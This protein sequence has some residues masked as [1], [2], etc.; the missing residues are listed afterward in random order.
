[1]RAA[2]NLTCTNQTAFNNAR[3][4]IT[5]KLGA[6]ELA[7]L[8]M[9]EWQVMLEAEDEVEEHGDW[10]GM[11]IIQKTVETL[12]N[13]LPSIRS[14]RRSYILDKEASEGTESSKDGT[15]VTSKANSSNRDFES[16]IDRDLEQMGTI[17]ESARKQETAF[18][19]QGRNVRLFSPTIGKTWM[20]LEE[21]QQSLLDDEKRIS[22]VN[23]SQEVG[24]LQDELSRELGMQSTKQEFLSYTTMD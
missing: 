9:E 3:M 24:K 14:V 5:S 15:T 6:E 20:R 22:R 11:H 18:Q 7:H 8:T 23:K 1:M 16:L 17:E 10:Q 13:V 21:W 2:S 12:F 4:Q 19:A